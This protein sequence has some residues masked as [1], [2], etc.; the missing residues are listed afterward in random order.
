[1]SGISCS[2]RARMSKSQMKRMLIFFDFKC[3]F[4]FEFIQQ[5]ETVNQDFCV[6]ILKRL[7]EAVRR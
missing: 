6:K 7:P 2:K 1:M 4:D 5:G 3:I